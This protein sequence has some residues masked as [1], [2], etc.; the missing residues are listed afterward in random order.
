MTYPRVYVSQKTH[1][2]VKKIA[3]KN[4]TSMSK[5]GNKI[6]LAGLKALGY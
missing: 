4:G 6:V 5:L 2:R 1:D 3:K